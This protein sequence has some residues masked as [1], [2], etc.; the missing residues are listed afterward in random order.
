[1]SQVVNSELVR[2]HK[3]LRYFNLAKYEKNDVNTRDRARVRQDKTNRH[4]FD[5][6]VVIEQALELLESESY[7]SKVARLYLLI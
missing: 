7:V 3:A 6:V 4:S 1:M 2:V 5:A